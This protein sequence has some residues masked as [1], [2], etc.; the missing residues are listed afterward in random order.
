MAYF[1]WFMQDGTQKTSV[2]TALINLKLFVQQ[3][4]ELPHFGKDN[5][6]GTH[7]KSESSQI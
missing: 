6:V 7:V 5:R 2:A 4:F 1:H 3:N